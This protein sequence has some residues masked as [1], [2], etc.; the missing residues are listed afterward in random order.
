MVMLMLALI[1]VS[2]SQERVKSEIAVE[3]AIKIATN[4]AKSENYNTQDAAVEV[5]KY[6]KG[7][8]AG[9]IRTIMLFQTFSKEEAP[10]L[11]NNEFWM[12]YF[13]PKKRTVLGGDF[14]V[15]VDLYSGKVLG[16][17]AGK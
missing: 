9:P 4:I 3:N 8:E 6:K 17:I 1:V 5:I 2:C 15:L 11:I 7:I 12:I 14:C 10:K 13:Y 16:A